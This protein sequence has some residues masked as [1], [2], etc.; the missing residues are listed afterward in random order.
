MSSERNRRGANHRREN[1]CKRNK[2]DAA[3]NPELWAQLLDLCDF[4]Q[5]EFRWMHGHAG[6]PDNERCD[7]LSMSAAQRSGLPID[8]VYEQQK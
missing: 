4:H 7:V 3:E 8:M 1:N 6:I 5:V 2:K